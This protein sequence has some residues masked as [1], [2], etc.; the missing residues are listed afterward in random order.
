MNANE[1][2][3]V[4]RTRED[5]L[6]E[7]CREAFEASI[8]APDYHTVEL[9][10][11]GHVYVAEYTD[12]QSESM[13]V[14]AGKALCIASFGPY[15]PILELSLQDEAEYIAQNATSDDAMDAFRSHCDDCG[16]APEIEVLREYDYEWYLRTMADVRGDVVANAEYEWLYGGLDATVES[17]REE[18]AYQ[19][20]F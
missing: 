6:R 15:D 18:A 8:W 5:E 12:A 16:I 11:D 2:L 9:T 19:E 4:V 14:W 1:W 10:E 20:S 3:D 13:D 7:A 17:L